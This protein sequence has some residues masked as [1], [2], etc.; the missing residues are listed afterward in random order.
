[1]IEE[2]VDQPDHLGDCRWMTPERGNHS[3]VVPARRISSAALRIGASGLRSRARGG[4]EVVLLAI[5]LAQLHAR[6]R[7]WL[8]QDAP[9]DLERS[10]SPSRVRSVVRSS[11]CSNRG[12][13]A[14]RPF[15]LSRSVKSRDLREAAQVSFVI[16]EGRD[17]D[18]RPT[19]AVLAH[20]PALILKLPASAAM[21]SSL[22]GHHCGRLRRIEAREVLA[23]DLFVRAL[24]RCAPRSR[25]S[26]S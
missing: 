16:A 14:Q 15:R 12:A 18:I 23:Q 5:G 10:V 11:T 2:V 17:D 21:R 24:D 13:H 3:R 26:P 4:E 8:E 20:P 1:V 25:S 7:G 19:A 6:S 9:I 22:S